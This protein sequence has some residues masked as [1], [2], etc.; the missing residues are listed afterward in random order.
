MREYSME[1]Q[2]FIQIT[3]SCRDVDKISGIKGSV[4]YFEDNQKRRTKISHILE[5]ILNLKKI[6]DI[7]N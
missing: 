4:K 5:N 7:R 6:E 3:R 2:V 1:N